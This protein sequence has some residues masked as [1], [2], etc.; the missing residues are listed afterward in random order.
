MT[1]TKLS[2]RAKLW[3]LVVAASVASFAI[4][5]AGLYLNYSRMHADRL[6]TLHSIVETG[7]TLATTLEADAAAGKITRDEAQARFKAAVAG[8]RYAGG[9]EYLFAHT[10][11]G[12]GF[13]HVNAK[14]IGAD[15]K[16]LKSANGVHMIV[17][18]IRMVRATGDGLLEYDWP[19]TVGGSDLAVK[20][21]YV[22]GF[23]P[24]NIFIGTGIFIDDI[25]AA[26][27]DQLR[28][29]AFVILAL[30]VPAV[31]LIAWVGTDISRV[32]RGLGAKMRSL[33]DGDLSTRFP[34]AERGDEIG[35][36]AKAVLV[37]Q[38]NARDKQRL[39]AEQAA[40]AQRAEEEKHRAMLALAASFEQSIGAVVRTVSD[41]AATMEERAAEMSR[42]AAQT[43]EL[44]TS[45]AAAT[46]QTS[47]NVQTVA[48]A[49][50]EL[51]G[52]IQEISRQ[53]AESSRIAGEA[54][55]LSGRAN[56][57]VGGL[58]EAVQKIGAVVQLI[59]D[60][61]SQTNLL[62][63]NATIEAARAGEA[64]KGFAVVASEVK[65]LAN[66]TAKATEEIA[67][68][69]A[70]IQSVTGDAVGEIQGVTQVI[71]R[72]NE[73]ATSIA[74]A[75]EEQGAATREIS[76]NVQEA[77]G[78]TQEVS[79]NITGVTG[80]ATQ[81]GA[82]ARD[83]LEMSRQLGH[84]LDTLHREVGGFLQQLRAA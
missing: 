40:S 31:G 79:A 3:A 65:A 55:T 45:V 78:G 74:S 56:D 11:D 49:S 7:V 14:L 19:R 63:L 76:R 69:V 70:N 66:Q 71:L 15:V 36:M 48:A 52:S 25:R 38:N 59:N 81:S 18:F 33:A 12:Y 68:Q 5:G 42:A 83:V 27:L 60:I 37:F 4:A 21:G 62:A 67:A 22:R 61:A 57:K 44:A 47:A 80:A 9:K 28:T 1:L 2:I 24:W 10:M 84:Q 64:G 73:I 46:E 17:E 58:A 53:V 39:E 16:P 32:L 75:V 30:A 26:F 41:A 8:I 51:A 29:L 23:E 72:V 43:D 35:A 20:L 77:A 6:D 50:E 13:A 34:E 54:V 82:T